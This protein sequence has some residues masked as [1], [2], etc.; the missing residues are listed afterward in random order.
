MLFFWRASKVSYKLFV[1]LLFCFVLLKQDQ[2][3]F[4]IQLP[5]H[6]IATSK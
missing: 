4:E 5:L 6:P 2:F 3:C 1:G